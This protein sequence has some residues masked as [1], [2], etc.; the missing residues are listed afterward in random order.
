MRI[1]GASFAGVNPRRLS[2]AFSVFLAK[3]SLDDNARPPEASSGD[4]GADIVSQLHGSGLSPTSYGVRSE[5]SGADLVRNL[6]PKGSHHP[7]GAL[8]HDGVLP[9]RNVT[10]H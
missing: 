6:A 5:V 7:D 4:P 8:H 2:L 9:V 10:G 1:V 3:R